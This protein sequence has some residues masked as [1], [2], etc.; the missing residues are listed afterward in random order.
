MNTRAWGGAFLH[1]LNINKYPT[2]NH[3]ILML[4]NTTNPVV[5]HP[6]PTSNHNFEVLFVSDFC[7][8]YHPFPTSNHNLGPFSAC[9]SGIYATF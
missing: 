3:N 1:P 5:Y 9:L 4:A 7:V 8:V 6:F 2:S